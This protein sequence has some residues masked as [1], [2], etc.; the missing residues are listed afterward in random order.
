MHMGRIATFVVFVGAAVIAAGFFGIVH[1]E[2]SYTVSSEYFTKCKFIQ[3]HLLDTEIPERIRAAAVGFRA[4]WWMGLPIGLL[5]GVGG[6]LERSPARMRRTLGWS[7]ILVL[8]FTMAF[9][10]CGLCYGMLRTAHVDL[11][12]YEGWFIP[13]D[14]HDPRAFLRAGY[15]HNA[16][17]LG[18]VLSI[19]MAWMFQLYRRSR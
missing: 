11:A 12:S 14:L 17:Y 13:R 2:V 19:P 7:I 15:M 6:F 1:D 8:G 16:A 10:L 3:F 9:A 18:G 4:S 5:V